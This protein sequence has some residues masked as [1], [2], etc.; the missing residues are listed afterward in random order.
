MAVLLLTSGCNSENPE[1]SSGYAI[2][3]TARAEAAKRDAI[4]E[5]VCTFIGRERHRPYIANFETIIHQQTDTAFLR[6]HLYIDLDLRACQVSVF[7]AV[8]P[9]QDTST[10]PFFVTR[11]GDTIKNYFLDFELKGT[12][13][14]SARARFYV[15]RNG[16]LEK[17]VLSPNSRLMLVR[18]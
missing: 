18:R 10:R 6:K 2:I 7:P 9:A 13:V 16:T 1:N 17:E 15:L 14:Q 4:R 11:N 5:A 3:T 8:Y 12:N